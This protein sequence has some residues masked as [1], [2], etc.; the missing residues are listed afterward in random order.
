M[1]AHLTWFFNVLRWSGILLMVLSWIHGG[2]YCLLYIFKGQ[3]INQI[4]EL[5]L[6]QHTNVW[7][8]CCLAIMTV[9]YFMSTPWFRKLYFQ[10]LGECHGTIFF[11]LMHDHLTNYQVC[12]LF[13]CMAQVF[14][15]IHVWGALLSLCF[16]VMHSSSIV[17]FALPGIILYLLDLTSRRGLEV[18]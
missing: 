7:G 14:K 10:V 13:I 17:N 3:L 5:N 12:F 16:L 8:T 11:I 4:F 1:K 2:L 9:M 18:Q 6:T 15:R